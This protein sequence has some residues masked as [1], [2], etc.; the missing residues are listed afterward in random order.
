MRI[1]NII[2][3]GQLWR[4]FTLHGDSKYI[5]SYSISQGKYTF[6]KGCLA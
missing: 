5:V 2:C 1:E 3:V 6:R 4:E